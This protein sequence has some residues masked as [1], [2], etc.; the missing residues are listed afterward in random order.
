MKIEPVKKEV[1]PS[2]DVHIMYFE[3]V[4]NRLIHE[5]ISHDKVANLIDTCQADVNIPPIKMDELEK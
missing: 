4:T 2:K 5:H 1:Q 3:E